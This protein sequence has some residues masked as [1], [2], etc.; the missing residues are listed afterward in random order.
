[1]NKES[2]RI[3]TGTLAVWVISLAGCG[4]A[5]QQ[6]AADPPKPASSVR[7]PSAKAVEITLPDDA[8]SMSLSGTLAPN[9]E[10][11]YVI[12]RAK[13][14]ILAAQLISDEEGA[15]VTV[16]RADTGKGLD[17]G[18]PNPAFWIARVPE[19]MGYLIVVHGGPKGGAYSL[20]V[21]SP[22]ELRWARGTNAAEVKDSLP[23]NAV[24]AY[25]VPSSEKLAIE[26]QSAG[27]DAYLTLEGLQGQP[28]VKAVDNKQSFTGPV[29]HDNKDESIVRVHQGAQSGEFTLRVRPL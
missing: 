4:G 10:A 14:S 1:V 7:M 29:P 21:E 22:R 12:G 28:V 15:T 6:K 11:E 23:A 26:L 18:Q 24:A 13:M 27:K 8:T 16:H 20:E 3:F 25:V 17:D 5:T 2:L 9:G 19:T